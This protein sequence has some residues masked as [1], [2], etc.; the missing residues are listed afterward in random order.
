MSHQPN[1]GVTLNGT[2]LPDDV[3]PNRTDPANTASNGPA[4]LNEQTLAAFTTF[5]GAGKLKAV[6]NNRVVMLPFAL[7]DPPTVLSVD[8]AT[9][10]TAKIGGR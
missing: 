7:T 6:A 5:P 2:L 9:A 10:L 4:A 1:N 3:V 8:G